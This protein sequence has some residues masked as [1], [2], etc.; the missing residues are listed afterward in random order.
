MQNH[1]TIGKIT[2]FDI[3]RLFFPVAAGEDAFF[4]IK[5]NSFEVV[6]GEIGSP[7]YPGIELSSTLKREQ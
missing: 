5:S 4:G 7:T 3:I 2:H 1:G 6:H